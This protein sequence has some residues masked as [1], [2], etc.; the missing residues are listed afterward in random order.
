MGN[1]E[2]RPAIQR[3]ALKRKLLVRDVGIRVHERFLLM[4][5]LLR[6]QRLLRS[7]V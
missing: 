7:V 6:D 1:L 5:R 4:P 3:V 2:R